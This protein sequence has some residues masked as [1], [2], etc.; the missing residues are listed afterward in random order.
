VIDLC[1]P[2]V[3]Q[4]LDTTLEELRMPWLPLNDPPSNTRPQAAPTQILGTVA[5]QLGTIEALRYPSLKNPEGVNLV[6]FSDR[7]LP[8]QLDIVR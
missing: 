1:G 4:A 2:L 5:Y 8:G 7:L 6:L 3:Q